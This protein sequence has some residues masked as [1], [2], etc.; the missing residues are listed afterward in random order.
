MKKYIC[1]IILFCFASFITKAKQTDIYNTSKGELKITMLGWS[2]VKFE[3]NNKIIYV[4]PSLR[5]NSEVNP[6]YDTL[7]KADYIFIT[8]AHFDHFNI[9]VIKKLLKPET[10]L[11]VNDECYKIL[12][13]S[14]GKIV[15]TR[16]VNN[17]EYDFA[18]LE[19]FVTPAYNLSGEEGK[20]Y[21][22]EGVGNGYIFNFDNFKV[23]VAGD[24]ENIPELKTLKNIDVAFLPLNRPFTMDDNMFINLVLS[25]KPKIVYP[26]HYDDNYLA[27]VIK[28]LNKNTEIELKIRQVK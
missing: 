27:N 12:G 14:L 10:H 11:I 13:T 3:Y 25:F 15:I 22:P 7:A 5:K 8:H 6:N 24:T 23:L 17:K 19:F 16:V 21:H 28:A 9:E 2:G 1:F 26:Y 4:D 18:G 20:I